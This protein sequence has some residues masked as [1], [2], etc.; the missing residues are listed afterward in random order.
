MLKT[1]LQSLI[2]LSIHNTLPSTSQGV[3]IHGPSPEGLFHVRVCAEY[4]EKLHTKRGDYSCVF[5]GGRR[6]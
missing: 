2:D 3:V 1:Y 5:F 4:R 6:C